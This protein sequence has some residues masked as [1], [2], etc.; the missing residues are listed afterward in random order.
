MRLFSALTPPSEVTEHLVHT[1]RPIKNSINASGFSW[2]DPDNWHITLSF[3]GEEPDGNVD[4]ISASLHNSALFSNRFAI[5]LAGAGSFNSRNLWIGVGG[6]S[7]NLAT[8]MAD[9]A[10]AAPGG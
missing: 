7:K 2:V 5:D 9:V 6:Q 1:L 8:L 3:Y 10:L 4:N